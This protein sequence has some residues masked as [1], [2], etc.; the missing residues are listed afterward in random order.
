[1]NLLN[2]STSLFTKQSKK[3]RKNKRRK[4]VHSKTENASD[5]PLLDQQA[6]QLLW[7]LWHPDFRYVKLWQPLVWQYPG[8]HLFGKPDSV[9]NVFRWV[10]L[11]EIIKELDYVNKY[12]KFLTSIRLLSTVNLFKVSVPVLS[13]QRTSIPAISSIAVILFVIAPYTNM[14]YCNAET[15]QE[16]YIFTS[17]RIVQ[18]YT[19]WAKRCDPIAIVTERTVGMAMGIPPIRSTKRLSIPGR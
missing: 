1:M 5:I 8:Q 13:L 7:H 17:E 15:D 6:Y 11:S 19:C 12:I 10:W 14:Q 9:K 18:I 2:T 3:R 4:A 16:T